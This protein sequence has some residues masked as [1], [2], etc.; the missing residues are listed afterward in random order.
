M[1]SRDVVVV[2]EISRL[3]YQSKAPVI[4]NRS[5]PLCS[6]DLL[7]PGKKYPNPEETKVPPV[8]KKKKVPE[9]GEGKQR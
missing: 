4:H 7:V 3:G 5:P 6:P 2:L 9:R 8:R 1:N